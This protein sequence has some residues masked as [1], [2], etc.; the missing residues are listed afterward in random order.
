MRALVQRKTVGGRKVSLL[1]ERGDS[2]RSNDIGDFE[3]AMADA[4]TL[5]VP[6][7]QAVPTSGRRIF[8]N[9]DESSLDLNV[10]KQLCELSDRKNKT[11]R[12]M[13]ASN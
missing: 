11:V 5:R 10:S 12:F 1:Q 3:A 13:F 9:P 8:Y 7:A 2:P 4:F 6:P